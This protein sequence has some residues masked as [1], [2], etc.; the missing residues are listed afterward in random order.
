VAKCRARSVTPSAPKAQA[1][2]SPP[3]VIDI[4]VER[5]EARA[6]G[7]EVAPGD[8]VRNGRIA[9]LQEGHRGFDRGEVALELA[10]EGLHPWRARLA[11]SARML[12]RSASKPSRENRRSTSARARSSC[13]ADMPRER[14]KPVR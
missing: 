13:T 12:S 7:Q 8:A 14:R 2:G 3:F 4:G 9:P 11:G 5:L 1:S 6:F 10:L